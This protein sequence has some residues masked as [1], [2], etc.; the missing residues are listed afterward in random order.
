MVLGTLNM[1]VKLALTL[2]TNLLWV[3]FKH[4]LS[5]KIIISRTECSTANTWKGVWS[6]FLFQIDYI[7]YIFMSDDGKKK[8]INAPGNNFLFGLAH[9]DFLLK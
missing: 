3:G 5:I 7:F 8:N 1:G 4:N 2:I 6:N 9:I